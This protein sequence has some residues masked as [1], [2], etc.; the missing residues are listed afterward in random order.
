MATTSAAPPVEAPY[1][2]QEDGRGWI[3]FASVVLGVAGVMRVFDA[4]W[5]FRY[6]GAVPQNLEESLFGHSLDTYGWIW[7][8]VAA[9]LIGSAVLVLGGSQLA[10]WVGVAAAAIGC[11]SA[12][13]WMPYYPIWSLTYIVLFASV[14]YALTAFGSRAEAT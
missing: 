7:L 11:V 2:T 9:V 3:V 12:V 5:A 4:I 6:K 13:W 1:G 8:A 14:I 10:R